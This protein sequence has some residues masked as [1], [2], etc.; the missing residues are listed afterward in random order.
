MVTIDSSHVK[1]G[2]TCRRLV[3]LLSAA[4][5]TAGCGSITDYFPRFL[6][7]YRPDVQQGNVITSDMVDQ[8]RPGMTRDQVKFMLGTPLLADAFHPDRWDYLYYLNP[9]VGAPQ[10][11]NLVIFFKDNRLDRF[12]SDPMPP[13]SMA[14][15]LILGRKGPFP[16]NAAPKEPAPAASE[17][18]KEPST[19]ATPPG[20]SPKDGA[21]QAAPAGEPSG[22]TPAPTTPPA[23]EPSGQTTAPA[24]PPADEAP[25]Q[26]PAPA[27]PPAD[28][29]SGQT[30]A[31]TTPPAGEPSKE[32]APQTAPTGEASTDVAPQA[33]ADEAPNETGPP[34]TPPAAE[35]PAQAAPVE[36]APAEPE[37]AVTPPAPTQ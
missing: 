5:I 19:E 26:T 1:W 35:A 28:E 4:L 20:E 24:T 17:T 7:P 9:R 15:N 31:P 27:T 18:P 22:Q 30:T 29:P 37:R 34:A 11:R 23:D 6:K 12:K 21:A 33:P 25:G 8:L 36:P 10:R 32:A 2:A 14:D 13:E 3:A 16:V